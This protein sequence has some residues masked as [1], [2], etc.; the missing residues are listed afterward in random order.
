MDGVG[1]AAGGDF[2]F[3]A[4]RDDGG[5]VAIFG[6]VYA[7]GAGLAH[8]ECEIWS[9]YFVDVAF[10]E[11]ADAEIDCAFGDADLHDVAVEIEER[12]GGH[13]AHVDG[14]GADLQFGA[15]RLVGPKLVTDGD[16]AILCGASPLTL[17]AGLKGDGA[18]EKTDARNTRRRIGCIGVGSGL[19]VGRGGGVL[20]RLCRAGRLDMIG[21]L[22]GLERERSGT[23]KRGTEDRL[24]KTPTLS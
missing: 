6:D 21:N 14:G 9:V 22:Q 13:A 24:T 17:A 11:F 23:T 10:A 3:A 19:T 20:I 4:D 8:G 5:G 2:A 18:V 1:L 7:E 16:G 12:E 15:R